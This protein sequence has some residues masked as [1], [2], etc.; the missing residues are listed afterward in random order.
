MRLIITEK[1]DV[2]KKIA[3][4]LAKGAVKEES[5]FRVPYYLFDDA[6]GEPTATVGLKGHI[7]QV[8][9]PPEYSEW[10]K[11]EPKSLIDAPL[12]KTETAKVVVRTVKKLAADAT[13]LIIA[14]D[15]DREGELIGLEALNLALEENPKL[16]RTVRRAWFSALT[17]NEITRAFEHLDYLSEPLAWVGEARQDIDLIWGATL[18]WFV[19]LLAHIEIGQPQVD[20]LEGRV[21]INGILHKGCGADQMLGALALARSVQ[22]LIESGDCQHGSGVF[23]IRLQHLQV[24]VQLLLIA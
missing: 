13:G 14:T 2:A 9:F 5:H 21:H 23:R 12:I 10:R 1:N 3:G 20:V 17:A 24:A 19:E 7:V 15:F 6:E 11:V 4:I 8:D 16:V 22:V 18:I